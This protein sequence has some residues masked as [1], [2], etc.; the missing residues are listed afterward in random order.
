[1]FGVEL[2]YCAD[3]LLLTSIFGQKIGSFF[4]YLLLATGIKI[5]VIL[6]CLSLY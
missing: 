6:N 2:G 4:V 5:G 1:M 3:T